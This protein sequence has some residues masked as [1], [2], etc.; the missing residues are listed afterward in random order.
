MTT[1]R[2]EIR[3]VLTWTLALGCASAF[4]AVMGA[5]TFGAGDLQ[6]IAAYFAGGCVLGCLVGLL[7]VAYNEKRK[8]VFHIWGW[9][10]FLSL[11]G[12]AFNTRTS[13]GYLF[14]ALIG[15]IAGALIGLVV[16]R[17]VVR[18]DTTEALAGRR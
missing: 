8:T 4:I 14:G 6:N 9:T 10:L 15:A 1:Q 3:R 17:R 13:R 5:K 2:S 7:M 16:Y 11:F 18:L 12:L